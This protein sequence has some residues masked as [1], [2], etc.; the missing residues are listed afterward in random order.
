ML[1]KVYNKMVR[2]PKPGSAEDDQYF[3]WLVARYAAYPN[4]IWDFSKEAHNEK[5]VDYK[6]GRLEL[7]RTLD[8]YHHPRTVH[9]DNAAY[10]RGRYDDVA[11]FRTDQ[12]HSR[13]HETILQQRKQH[14]WPVLN[15][16]FGYEHGPGGLEDKTYGVAQ[17]PEEVCRRAWEICLAGG[18]TVY[19]YTYTAWD[20][21]RPEDNPPG[22]AHFRRL[23]NFFETTGY[24]LMEPSD[25]LVSD[26]YCL[27]RRGEEYVAFQNA[28]KPFTLKLEGLATPLSAEWYQPSTGRRARP[29]GS[30]TGRPGSSLPPTGATGQSHCTS[31]VGPENEKRKILTTDNTNG[32]D[33]T[34]P[35]GVI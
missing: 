21:I 9:D 13:W 15:S 1:I 3:R 25:G 32:T 30:K 24:W 27:A 2:W 17:G 19:Y 8:P 28:A 5:D 35:F 31:G 11:D 10:D 7:L 33:G 22:Y 29:A 23:R 18:Y 6:R 4:V 20:V 34:N 12:Q 14:A 16:E 26:G